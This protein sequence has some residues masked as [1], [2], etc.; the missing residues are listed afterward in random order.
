MKF[1][2]DNIPDINQL[3]PEGYRTE[4][5]VCPDGIYED[6]SGFW[7]LPEIEENLPF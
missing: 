2:G 1:Y 3:Y 6:E 5:D 4:M 7:C